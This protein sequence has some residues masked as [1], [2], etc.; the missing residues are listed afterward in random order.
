MTT[1]CSAETKGS[2]N[3]HKSSSSLQTWSVSHSSKSLLLLCLFTSVKTTVRI[4]M[5]FLQLGICQ[6]WQTL[7][8]TRFYGVTHPK[9]VMFPAARLNCCWPRFTIHHVKDSWEYVSI[10]RKWKENGNRAMR[11]K[12]IIFKI[13]F[14]GVS[15]TVYPL[16]TYCPLLLLFIMGLLEVLKHNFAI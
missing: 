3:H 1:G 2:N 6:H 5:S 9:V 14:A 7:L 4:R 16:I 10:Y 13:I 8:L 15:F 11:L 12:M